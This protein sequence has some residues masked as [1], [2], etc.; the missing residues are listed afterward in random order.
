MKRSSL[1]CASLFPMIWLPREFP[2]LCFSPRSKGRPLRA[3]S[4]P[5]AGLSSASSPRSYSGE[6]SSIL[7]GCETDASA[8]ALNPCASARR[9]TREKAL[10][11]SASLH[12]ASLYNAATVCSPQRVFAMRK[13][14]THG[15][16][17]RCPRRAHAGGAKLYPKKA[18]RRLQSSSGF[19]AERQEGML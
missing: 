5:G 13:S 18:M 11:S 2:K 19:K 1:R 17:C 8:S 16:Q 6:S 15:Q 12:S 10:C 9:K 14:K 3:S 4:L 7:T